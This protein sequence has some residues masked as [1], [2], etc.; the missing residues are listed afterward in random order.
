MARSD[1][2]HEDRICKLECDLANM[3]QIVREDFGKRG[4]QLGEIGDG[5]IWYRVPPTTAPRTIWQ[6][7]NDYF[8]R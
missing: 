3:I 2:T 7:L 5:Y 4:G 8:S 1:K 6:R